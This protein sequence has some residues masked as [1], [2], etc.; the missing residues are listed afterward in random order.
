[1]ADRPDLD[2]ALHTIFERA[3]YAVRLAGEAY[4]TPDGED[5]GGKIDP[6]HPYADHIIKDTV[7]LAIIGLFLLAWKSQDHSA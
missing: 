2:E 3:E 1:M 6:I 5:E 7:P 4:M